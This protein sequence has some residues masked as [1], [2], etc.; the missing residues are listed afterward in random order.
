MCL[1]LSFLLLL[2]AA[3]VYFSALSTFVC[4]SLLL[5]PLLS[6]ILIF[7][8]LSHVDGA[9]ISKTVQDPE[10]RTLR[11]GIG[12]GCRSLSP[13]NTEKHWTPKICDCVELREVQRKK[14]RTLQVPVSQLAQ[15]V[16]PESSVD[17][18]L[19]STNQQCPYF[20]ASSAVCP[21]MPVTSVRKAQSCDTP[22]LWQLSSLWLP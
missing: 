19:L 5:S 10:Y 21:V 1:H 3:I 16:I 7:L 15:A 8:H 9:Q 4:L 12:T 18:S 20:S 6:F 11:A 22:G 2:F 13:W 17:T 14:M